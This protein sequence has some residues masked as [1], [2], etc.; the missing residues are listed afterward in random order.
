[1]KRFVVGL[2][3]IGSVIAVIALI[4]RRRS[5]SDMDEWD[6]FA[7]DTWTRASSTATKIPE[8]AEDAGSQL[9]DTA[10]DAASKV[11]DTAEEAISEVSDAAKNA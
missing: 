5:G 4:V 1:M 9:S 7:E 10:K 3:I 2:L 11:S 8:A 6:S